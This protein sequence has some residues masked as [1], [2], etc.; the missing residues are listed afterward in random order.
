M[1]QTE[2]EAGRVPVWLRVL[3]VPAY[4]IR[5]WLGFLRLW[6]LRRISALGYVDCPHC[7]TE[8][9]VDILSTCPRC[10]TTEYGSRLRCTGCDS[11]ARSFACDH[12]GVTIHC[13]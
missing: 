9:A 4:F 13:L 2:R 10:K 3:A 1:N 7:G 11:R 12:C 5:A 8:N 6:R